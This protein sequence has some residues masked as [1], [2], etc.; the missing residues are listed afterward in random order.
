[1][2]ATLTYKG[3]T[4]TTVNNETKVLNTSGT[5]LEDN[6][7]IT[8]VASGIT[9]AGTISIDDEGT[10]NVTNY[11]SAEV[12][13]DYSSKVRE[14]TFVINRQDTSSSRVF[15]IY[16]TFGSTLDFSQGI[17]SNTSS[18]IIAA[19]ESTH[20]YT[21][22]CPKQRPIIVVGTAQAVGNYDVT[23]NSSYGECVDVPH[24]LGS[25]N[26]AFT[27]AI[28]LKT[29]APDTFTITITFGSQ[30]VYP[31][32]VVTSSLSVTTNGTYT[33][34][35]GTAYNEVTVN[36]PS[37]SAL[38]VDTPDSHG[39]TIREI[40]AQNEV[41]LQA[42]KTITPA[43][44][45]QTV[46]PDTGYDGF[47]SVI[48]AAATG[49]LDYT[50]REVTVTGN[51]P[52][53]TRDFTNFIFIAQVAEDELPTTRPN[54]NVYYL[55]FA[56]V[57]GNFIRKSGNKAFAVVTTN[58]TNYYNGAGTNAANLSVGSTSIT[59]TAYTSQ[60][61]YPAKWKVLQIELPTD[62]PLYSFYPLS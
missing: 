56:F 21:I 51:S 32:S 8:D 31:E 2:S 1:M 60:I 49:G 4:L 23:I 61:M 45:Q 30:A 17:N 41:V 43:S 14:I 52:T 7:T 20:S 12:D 62:Y 59:F 42:Q 24:V 38:V 26:T 16:G 54:T 18:T 34:S 3:N 5:W 19:G 9:P 6:I 48:V 33:A 44:S 53:V 40:T 50:V 46:L 13:I 15:S 35:S 10:Y 37:G 27:K 25:T 11:A 58:S 55:E 57:D 47:A 39:G 29:A 28:Y 36:V 22:Y